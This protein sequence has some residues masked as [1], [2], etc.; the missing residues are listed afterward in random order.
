M[1]PAAS[2]AQQAVPNRQSKKNGEHADHKKRGNPALR[3]LRAAADADHYP[4]DLIGAV[5]LGAPEAVLIGRE[6]GREVRTPYDDC[7]L[8]MPSRCSR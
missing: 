5:R 2:G 7:V 3:F 4:R 6:N 1:R 8:I